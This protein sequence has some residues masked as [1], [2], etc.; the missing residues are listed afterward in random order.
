MTDMLAKLYDLPPLEPVIEKQAEQ[1]IIIRRALA[2]EKHF[3]LAWVKRHFSDFWFSETDIA[4]TRI[5][6]SC[7][8]ATKEGKLVGFAC[9]DTTRLGFFGP[10]G[11]AEDSRGQ[12][13]GKAL[14]LACLRDMWGKGYGY[15]IIGNVGPMEFYQRACGATVIP[16]STP[17][18][19]AGLMRSY[20]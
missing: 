2:P 12:G 15:A 4:F 3:V 13:I 19:Y 9:Y 18:V 7:F 14:L 16:D 17:G 11:V 8:I 1:G 5:P 10:T 6:V 20:T